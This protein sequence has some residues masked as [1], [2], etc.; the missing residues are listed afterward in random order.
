MKVKWPYCK[1][2]VSRTSLI[3]RKEFQKLSNNQNDK[4]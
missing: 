4:H 3:R 2:N 1:G